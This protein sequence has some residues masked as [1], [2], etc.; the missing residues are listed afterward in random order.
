MYDMGLDAFP[1]HF[2]AAA[3]T[4]CVRVFVFSTQA[5]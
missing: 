5:L 4:K 1:L 2:V 3:Y